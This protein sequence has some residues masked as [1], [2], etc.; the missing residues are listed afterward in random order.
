MLYKRLLSSGWQTAGMSL[1]RA[2]TNGSCVLA[3]RV[4][5][6]AFAPV[7]PQV[8]S[9]HSRN[10][11]Q[12]RRCLNTCSYNGESA[13]DEVVG[14]SMIARGCTSRRGRRTGL[15]V[16]QPARLSVQP[17]LDLLFEAQLRPS[18]Q[19]QIAGGLPPGSG[20]KKR[21]GRGNREALFDLVNT[22]ENARHAAEKSPHS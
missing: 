21:M 15:P 16:R 18:L 5:P 3:T 1:F 19:R 12:E 11:R 17:G 2:P 9:P 22:K 13:F 8:A 14:P 4:T 6:A 7:A 20:V 10:V